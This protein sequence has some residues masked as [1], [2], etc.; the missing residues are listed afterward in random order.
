MPIARPRRRRGPITRHAGARL[1]IAFLMLRQMIEGAGGGVA[2]PGRRTRAGLVLGVAYAFRH[3]YLPGGCWGEWAGHGERWNKNKKGTN[4]AP[5]GHIVT[6]RKQSQ[7]QLPQLARPRRR[8]PKGPRPFGVKATGEG[9]GDRHRRSS[10]RRA[11]TGGHSAERGAVKSRIA[12]GATPCR[13]QKKRTRGSEKSAA[14][15]LSSGRPH[16][17][18]APSAPLPPRPGASPS[19]V[20]NSRDTARPE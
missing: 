2:A 8:R 6:W 11:G 4:H 18:P 10:S 19:A 13:H 1:D 3:K 14:P 12:R 5:A 15:C 16:G 9:K 17:E 7:Q 20:R